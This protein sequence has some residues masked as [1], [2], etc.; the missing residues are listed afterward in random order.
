M[1]YMNYENKM[2]LSSYEHY[3][4]CTTHLVEEQLIL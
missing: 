2:I 1:L 4:R 3:H